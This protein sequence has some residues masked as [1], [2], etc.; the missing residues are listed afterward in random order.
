MGFWGKNIKLKRFNIRH[1]TNHVLNEITK[2]KDNA[3]GLDNGRD[4]KGRW[5]EDTTRR[6]E[7]P[8]VTGCYRG[9]GFDTELI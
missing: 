9:S 3:S 5:S 7:S 6:R 1:R 2:K 4:P 8:K